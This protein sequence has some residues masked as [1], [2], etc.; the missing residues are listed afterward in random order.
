ML[1]SSTCGAPFA[2]G[3][4]KQTKTRPT[5]REI[6]ITSLNGDRRAFIAEA[7]YNQHCLFVMLAPKARIKTGRRGTVAAR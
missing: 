1:A 2:N 4:L 6:A 7:F 5:S 3:R